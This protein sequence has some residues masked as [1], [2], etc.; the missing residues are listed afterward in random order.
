MGSISI[1][2]L[3]KTHAWATFKVK[4]TV[5]YKILILSLNNGIHGDSVVVVE[6][7]GGILP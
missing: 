5:R 6:G 2:A 1:F 7:Q 3:E 4:I